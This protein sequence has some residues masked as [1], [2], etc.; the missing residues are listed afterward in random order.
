MGQLLLADWFALERRADLSTSAIQSPAQEE[1]SPA[2][3]HR[4]IGGGSATFSAGPEHRWPTYRIP[5]RVQP[6]QVGA[7]FRGMLVAQVPVL[8]QSL[9]D[10]VFQLGW[11][12]RIHSHRRHWRAFQNCVEDQPEVSPRNGSVPVAISYSTAPKENRSVRASSSFPRA[13]SGDM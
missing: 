7:H 8:L 6:L 9:V 12:V 11:Q 13:C 4:V 10:D 1:Q 2:P 3:P 5:Y